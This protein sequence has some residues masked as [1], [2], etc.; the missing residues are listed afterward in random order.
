M[1]RT[2]CKNWEKYWKLI[3][4]E[5]HPLKNS[6]GPWPMACGDH[7]CF[8]R[9][10]GPLNPL[11]LGLKSTPPLT[12]RTPGAQPQPTFRSP[13]APRTD[14]IDFWTPRGRSKNRRFFN[15]FQ[16][17]PKGSNNRPKGAPVSIFHG[18]QCHFWHN[19]SYFLKYVRKCAKLW[20]RT[21][22]AARARF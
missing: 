7:T 22:A 20:N 11:T 16:N 1:F 9:P 6:P 15:P 5:V 13:A 10:F 17:R 2:F 14:F 8:P 21:V 12:R 3:I 4:L 18:F 19:F